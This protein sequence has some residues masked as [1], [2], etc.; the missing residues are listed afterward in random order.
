[1]ITNDEKDIRAEVMAPKIMWRN[2]LALV[3]A[4]LRAKERSDPYYKW[5]DQAKNIRARRAHWD[6]NHCSAA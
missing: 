1:M 2:S 3:R 6:A 4:H 5:A